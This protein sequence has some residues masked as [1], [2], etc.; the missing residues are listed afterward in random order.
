LAP[1]ASLLK[2]P[3]A[4]DRLVAKAHDFLLQEEVLN[5]LRKG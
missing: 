1:H 2:M 4:S 3:A 5:R